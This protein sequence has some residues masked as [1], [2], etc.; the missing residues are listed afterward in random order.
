[1]VFDNICPETTILCFALSVK[2]G[3]APFFEVRCRCIIP[4]VFTVLGEQMCTEIKDRGKMTVLTDKFGE[5]ALFHI[6]YFCDGKCIVFLE[7]IYF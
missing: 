5:I 3:F 2:D 1:M 4:A 6:K 7:C